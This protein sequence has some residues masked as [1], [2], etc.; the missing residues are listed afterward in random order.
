MFTIKLYTSTGRQRIVEAE[1]FTVLRATTDSS[2]EITAHGAPSGDL[3]F[4]VGPT[5]YEPDG[6]NWDWAFIVNAAG[7]TIENL[8]PVILPGSGSTTS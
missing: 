4:D 8:R 1:S 5:G 3:R 7:K 2:F 6:G